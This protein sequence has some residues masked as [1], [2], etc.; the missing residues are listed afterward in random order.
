M[1]WARDQRSLSRAD[2]RGRPSG[3]AQPGRSG[4]RQGVPA[5]VARLDAKYGPRLGT[6]M[7]VSTLT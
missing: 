1:T 2:S 3:N 5:G 4:T 7:A 6:A